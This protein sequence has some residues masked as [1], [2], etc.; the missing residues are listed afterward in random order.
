MAKLLPEIRTAMG[1][2]I[3]AGDLTVT[4]ESQSL[5]L[6]ANVLIWNMGVVWNRPAAVLVSRNNE[7]VRIPI[8][9]LTRIGMIVAGGL[10]AIAALLL[11]RVQSALEV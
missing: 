4:P 6:V 1:T 10:G 9:N 2:P 3:E 11:L 5:I 7:Q 8:I